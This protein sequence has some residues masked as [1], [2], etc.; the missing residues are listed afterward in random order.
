MNMPR[1]GIAGLL[2]TALLAGASAAAAS[3]AVPPPVAEWTFAADQGTSVPDTSGNQI[4]GILSG[5]VTQ[6]TGVAGDALSFDGTPGMVDVPDALLLEPA[7]AVTV[8]AWVEGDG[9]PGVFRYIA[10]KGW[11]SCEASSYALYSGPSGGLQF[12]VGLRRNRQYTRSPD[13]GASIWNGAWHLV[14]GT[15]DGSV[16]RLYVDG[17]EVGSGAADAGNLDYGLPGSNDFFI[18]DYPGCANHTFVGA[19]DDVRVW[20]SALGSA[21]IMALMPQPTGNPS[22]A[23]TTAGNSSSAGTSS[24]AGNSSSASSN[25]PTPTTAAVGQLVGSPSSDRTVLTPQISELR[26]SPTHFGSLRRRHHLAKVSQAGRGT[27]TYRDTEP[28]RSTLVVQRAAAGIRVHDRCVPASSPSAE[29]Q[30]HAPVCTRWVKVESF[31]HA[32]VIGHNTIERILLPSQPA[33]GRYRLQVSPVLGELH[34]SAVMAGFRV[35]G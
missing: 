33:V 21:Q 28:A 3:A 19:I 24:S 9:S 1:I 15:Y 11:D 2:T 12:Y 8:A 14:V 32:D 17:L 5:A 30:S 10:A 4:N 20:N 6:V 18:G 13:I 22:P 25:P 26:V 23:G 31:T 35:V 34:G 16:V 29:R 27:I 7:Q